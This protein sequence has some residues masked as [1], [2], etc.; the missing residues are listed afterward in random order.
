MK[1]KWPLISS[2]IQLC[3]GVLTVASFV[4]LAIAGED[5]RRWIVTVILAVAFVILGIVGI[6]D[7]KKC[8][9]GL[10]FSEDP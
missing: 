9:K 4:V 2:I 7:Y 6:V 1:K 3:I 5:M 10:D 8:G